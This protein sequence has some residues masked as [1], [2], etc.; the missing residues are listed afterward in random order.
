VN[1]ARFRRRRQRFRFAW[2]A[3]LAL[4][5]QQIALVAYACPQG[6]A[7][8]PP[9]TVMIGCEEMEMPDPAAP[10]LCDQHCQRDHLTTPDLRVAQV[11]PLALPPPQFD[12]AASLLPP[13]PAQHYRDVPTCRSDPPATERFC[14]LQI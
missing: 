6:E 14:S 2:L 7:P 10:L 9:Q 1:V 11:P 12:L 13:A 5:L 8:V 4:L 3:L